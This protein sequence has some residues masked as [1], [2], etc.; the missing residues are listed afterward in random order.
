MPIA[1]RPT[2]RGARAVHVGFESLGIGGQDSFDGTH[3]QL[4]DPPRNLVVER[5]VSEPG[6]EMGEVAGDHEQRAG[7]PQRS[8]GPGHASD[9]LTG[10]SRADQHGQADASRDAGPAGERAVRPRGC[11]R[12]GTDGRRPAGPGCVPT[13][14]SRRGRDR[15]HPAACGRRSRSVPHLRETRRSGLGPSSRTRSTVAP[16]RWRNPA[17]A[18]AP[19]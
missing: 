17:A 14:K 6:A 18:T 15:C 3:V 11:A 12:A 19:E 1:E 8:Q 2:D 4:L 7:T 13:R 16:T 10:S 9:L 5:Y